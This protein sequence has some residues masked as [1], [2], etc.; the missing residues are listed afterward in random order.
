MGVTHDRRAPDVFDRVVE[1]EDGRV[2]PLPQT[3]GTPRHTD[4]R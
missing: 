1:M 2:K 3:P 4:E